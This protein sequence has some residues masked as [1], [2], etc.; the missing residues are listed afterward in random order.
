MSLIDFYK[1]GTFYG[2]DEMTHVH[3][4]AGKNQAVINLFNLTGK[5]VS[6]EVRVNL[7]DVGLDSYRGLSGAEARKSKGGFTF[8]SE[9]K[10]LSQAVVKVNAGR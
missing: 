9:L 4:L 1:R 8:R 5:T 6:R 2:I 7:A 10:P 3:T